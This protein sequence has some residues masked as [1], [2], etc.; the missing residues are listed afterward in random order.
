M[1]AEKERVT[2]DQILNL[3]AVRDLLL[4]EAQKL[5]KMRVLI[6]HTGGEEDSD[7]FEARIAVDSW[8]LLLRN[9]VG[10]LSL[11]ISYGERGVWTA[12]RLEACSATELVYGAL[13]RARDPIY[14]NL[15]LPLASIASTLSKLCGDER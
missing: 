6:A 1:S 9:L 2:R 15:R 11:I 5:E 3:A 13:S 10:R 12:A 4:E 7:N 8:L 14:E